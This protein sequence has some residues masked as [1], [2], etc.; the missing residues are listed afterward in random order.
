MRLMTFAKLQL[1]ISP[2]EFW[3]LTFGEFW[4]LYRAVVGDKDALPKMTL[5]DAKD[6]EEAWQRGD[7]RRIS[8]TTNGGIKSA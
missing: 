7:F 6:I 5:D 1:Q 3:K 4:P 2:A 8:S